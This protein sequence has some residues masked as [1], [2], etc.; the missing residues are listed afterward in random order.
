MLTPPGEPSLHIGVVGGGKLALEPPTPHTPPVTIRQF[1]PDRG[2]S[3]DVAR[4]DLPV[5]GVTER[6]HTRSRTINHMVTE[7]WSLGV[8]SGVLTAPS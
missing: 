5:A 3:V 7:K 6:E 2:G 4:G 8:A 1:A